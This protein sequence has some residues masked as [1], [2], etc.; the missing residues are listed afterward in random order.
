[1]KVIIRFYKIY[2]I[3]FDYSS[4]LLKYLSKIIDFKIRMTLTG[5]HPH[6]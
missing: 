4:L 5:T 2:V 6:D 1:M 3:N